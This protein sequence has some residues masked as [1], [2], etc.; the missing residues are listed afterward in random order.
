MTAASYLTKL[1]RYNDALVLYNRLFDE[2][3]TSTEKEKAYFRIGELYQ[4]YLKDPEKAI[5]AYGMIVEKYP[6]SLFAEEA[7][8]RIRLLRGDA[9]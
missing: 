8:K 7:R 6:F 3:K 1:Q 4:L 9:I 2:F 5:S